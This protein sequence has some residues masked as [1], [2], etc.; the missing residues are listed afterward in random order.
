MVPAGWIFVYTL[1][2]KGCTIL[3]NKSKN[4]KIEVQKKAQAMRK[5]EAFLSKV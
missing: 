4:F 1:N 5:S 3:Q 2:L